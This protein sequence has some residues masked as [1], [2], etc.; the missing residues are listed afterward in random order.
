LFDA[1]CNHEVYFTVVYKIWLLLKITNAQKIINC[2][3][4]NTKMINK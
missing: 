3:N 2:E 4:S 1:R